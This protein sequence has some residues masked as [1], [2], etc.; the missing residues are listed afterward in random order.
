[1]VVIDF[2]LCHTMKA[3]LLA[4][5]GFALAMNGG[6]T[7]RSCRDFS[8]RTLFWPSPVRH[9]KSCRTMTP[10]PPWAQTPLRPYRWDS[11][12]FMCDHAPRTHI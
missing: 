1:V 8:R 3:S 10:S 9:D 7:G 5:V 11:L 2:L 6:Q 12:G 4:G